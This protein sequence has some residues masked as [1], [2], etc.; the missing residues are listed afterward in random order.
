MRLFSRD[1]SF[2]WQLATLVAVST[3]PLLA[4]TL[5]PTASYVGAERAR[6]QSL[7]HEASEDI[8]SK[9]DRDITGKISILRALA[10]SPAIDI[11]DFDR[12]DQQAR[13]LVGVERFH[14]SLRAPNG[15]QLVSTRVPRGVPLARIDNPN[16]GRVLA[17]QQPYISD[18]F[19]GPI[20]GEYLLTV[21]VPVIRGGKAVHVL[22]AGLSPAY[23]ADFLAQQ[24]LR[25]P[26]EAAIVD[27]NGRIIAAT[28]GGGALTGRPM[29][30]YADMT[31]RQG[32]WS[33]VNTLGDSV[34]RTYRRSALSG[35]TA[36]AAIKQTALT[37][38]LYRSL[39]LFLALFVAV[40]A[41]VLGAGTFLSRRMN[42]AFAALARA[43]KD[44][45]DGGTVVLPRT[46]L[47]E[48]NAIGSALAEAARKLR[49][50]SNALKR[51]NEALEAR[52]A[53]RTRDLTEAKEAA[54]LARAR[55]ERANRAKSQ[56]VASMSH[57]LRTP[58]NAISGFAQ[59]LCHTGDHIAR[60][61]HTRYA[62]N[63]LE[64]SEHLK[65]II[66]DV[67]DLARV[68]AGRISLNCTPLDCREVMSE[69]CRTLEVSAGARRITLNSDI[70]ADLPRVLADRARL[71]QVLLN[72]GSNAIK[73]NVAGGRVWLAASRQDGMV[74][75]SVRDTGQ[76]ISPEH[77]E[78][79]FEPFNRLGAERGPEE[80]A[81][82]G[83]AIS[84]QLVHAMRG[85][86]GF[87]SAVAA[88]SQFW[89]DLPLA[90]ETAATEPAAEKLPFVPAEASRFKVLYIE[91]K[92]ANVE[93]M[94]SILEDLSHTRLLDAQT[95]G[96][97]I[98]AARAVKPDLVI[99]DIHLP[100]GTGFDV[101]HKLRSDPE[102]AQVP[103]IAITADA[104]PANVHNMQRHRFDHILTKP[105]KVPD[106]INI[107]R[108]ALKAA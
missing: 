59:L 60:E 102:T 7:V 88:G 90:V 9:L 100:D 82:I 98:A 55:A 69:V 51:T 104:M 78:R 12:F 105:F 61:R 47:R 20:A 80:G 52:V 75:F 40:T 93:L 73:Y 96:G 99:T 24:S 97:G 8:L 89:I 16:D 86:I 49:E 91:D 94:R 37:A 35:W 13:E 23:F 29:M 54:E 70:A 74:R 26:N 30:G 79:V 43:S 19:Y 53:E 34:F 72:L 25:P 68:E 71:L 85:R 4:L 58:L 57:E 45:G 28:R 107:V 6:L 83:L 76:G 5:I 32:T 27:R 33:G 41:V 44:L 36:T 50:S 92:I 22:A 48:A 42:A 67:L 31:G 15:E 56:F 101:L 84:R 106:L 63:I 65:H 21:I 66:N 14:I 108:A 18:L 95:V 10:T 64:A 11:A 38:P 1:H 77:Q 46:R 39:W 2:R 3:M 17:S 81:G 87:E 62:H 103:I